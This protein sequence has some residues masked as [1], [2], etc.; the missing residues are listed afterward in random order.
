MAKKRLSMRKI[1]EV[2]RLKH[3]GGLS[4]RAIAKACSIG[5]ETVRAYLCRVSEAGSGWPIPEGLGDEEME[6]RLFHSAL[7]ISGKMSSPNWGLIHKEMRK[8]GVTTRQL[9][10]TEYR[11]EAPDFLGYSQFCELYR[12]WSRQLHPMM[13]VPH[14]AGEK[15][16]VD[17][18]GLTMSYT[19]TSSR[20]V[21]K[22]YVFVA[23]WGASN[24]TYA[25]AYPCQSLTSWIS[26]HV[27]AL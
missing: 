23:T 9:L 8:K 7:K 12:R 4:I 10:W 26:C 14:K 27:R 22:A 16:F 11:E 3:T 25:Q 13:R 24:Y 15:L 19:D 20:E 18:A 6:Q 17:F 1:R 21:K 5:K 2:L